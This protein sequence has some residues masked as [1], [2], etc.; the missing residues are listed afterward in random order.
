MKPRI[1]QE[2]W[3]ALG[4]KG[5]KYFRKNNLIY[6]RLRKK[7]TEIDYVFVNMEVNTINE[8]DGKSII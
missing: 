8:L 7:R 1:L 3:F 2:L 4:A 6:Q 5:T